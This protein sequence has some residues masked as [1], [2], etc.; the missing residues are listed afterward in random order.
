MTIYTTDTTSNR[1][2]IIYLRNKLVLETWTWKRKCTRYCET[3]AMVGTEHRFKNVGRTLQQH[4]WAM[5]VSTQVQ[6]F[7]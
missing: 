4:T 1:I 2:P 6:H 3:Y 5:V 7:K